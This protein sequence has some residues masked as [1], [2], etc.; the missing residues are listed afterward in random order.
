[1]ATEPGDLF[2][3]HRKKP[4][5][6]TPSKYP[7]E[8]K[9]LM[10]LYRTLYRE[11]FGNFPLNSVRHWVSLKQLVENYGPALVEAKIRY[12]IQWDDPF[13]RRAG[14]TIPV[15]YSQWMALDAVLHTPHDA[16]VALCRHEPKCLSGSEHTRRY[17]DSLAADPAT[18]PRS[19]RTTSK[20]SGV[21]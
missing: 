14:Y 16:A 8:L 2:D 3:L 17:L 19:S 4:R 1:M 21:C 18:V 10:M 9:R 15:F 20:R 5:K 6:K 12:F 11:K 13:V 7:G